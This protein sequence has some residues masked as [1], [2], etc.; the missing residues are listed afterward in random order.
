M[1]IRW[2][3][4]YTTTPWMLLLIPGIGLM[5]MALAILI[6]PQLLAYMIAL[7]LLAGGVTLTGWALTLRTAQKARQTQNNVHSTTHYE[8]L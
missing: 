3:R 7:A 2:Q 1:H 6:W 5:L 4:G 8:V